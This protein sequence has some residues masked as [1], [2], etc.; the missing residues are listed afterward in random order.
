M[1]CDNC[2]YK[3][4]STTSSIPYIVYEA[5]VARYER[6]VKQFWVIVILLIILL[7]GSNIAWLWYDAQ[8]EDVKIVQENADGYNNFIGNDG[9]IDNGK[10]DDNNPQT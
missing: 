4:T 1:S 2:Q 6:T 9:D 5:A 7:V 10:T 3:K 8:F